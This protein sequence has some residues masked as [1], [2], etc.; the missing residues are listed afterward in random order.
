MPHRLVHASCPQRSR[1]V[2]VKRAVLTLLVGCNQVYGLEPTKL[3]GPTECA[4]VRF[5]APQPL[6]EFDDGREEHDPQLSADRR[7]LWLV[8]LD[9][10]FAIYR[11]ERGSVDEPFGTPV[12]V[13]L[14]MSPT[15]DPS[16]TADGRRLLFFSRGSVYEGVRMGDAFEVRSV[17]GLP[18]FVESLDISWNGLR[19]YFADNDGILYTADRPS[20]DEPFTGVTMLFEDAD[21]PSVS[22]D[23]L[24]IFYE[25]Y[26][27]VD[28]DVVYRRVREDIASPFGPPEIVLQ[29]ADDADVNPD[30]ETLIVS[31]ESSGLAIL[32]RACP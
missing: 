24:E 27:D 5:G 17:V 2:E 8:Y 21:F 14:G 18:S 7:E 10:E 3:D 4:T 26:I 6:T 32:E 25:P 31:D 28:P 29:S 20:L 16:L 15:R 19:I 23:E 22:P 1:L 13:D 9:T 30:G 12:L 11:S